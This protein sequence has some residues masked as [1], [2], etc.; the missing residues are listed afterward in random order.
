[1]KD[2]KDVKKPQEDRIVTSF[3][4]REEVRQ[5][6]ELDIRLMSNLPSL[7]RAT[8]G[9]VPGEMI[10]ISGPTKCGKTL[11]AQTLTHEFAKQ[12]SFPLWF[13][14]EVTPRF[15][16]QAFPELPLFYM[17]RRLKMNAIDWVVK[18]I[19]DSFKEY[20]TRVVFLDHLHYLFD[21]ARTRNPSIEI[22]T[23][24][25][26]LKSLAVQHE[27]IIFLLCH[28]KKGA[29]E[30]KQLTYESIRDSSFVGQESD[31]VLMIV[32]NMKQPESNEARLFVEFHRRT[33]ALHTQIN[34]IKR[35]GY[36]VEKSS[37]EYHPDAF[38]ETRKDLA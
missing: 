22:G 36:L 19:L 12:N 35:G 31:C 7:D 34:L 26:V 25:R 32:R 15:F 3:E 27:L 6:K 16:L 24:I 38:I 21:I 18:K 28:T 8:E 2:N 13:S 11:F 37:E 30:I 4:M 20:H 23:I 1:M 9:F 14:Y 5:R 33:G 10:S 29:S 17:P